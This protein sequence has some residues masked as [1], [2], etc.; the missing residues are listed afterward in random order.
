MIKTDIAWKVPWKFAYNLFAG[1][2]PENRCHVIL[3]VYCVK[4]KVYS[5]FS[6]SQHQCAIPGLEGRSFDYLG[7]LNCAFKACERQNIPA[8]QV[9][10]HIRLKSFEVS[11]SSCCRFSWLISLLPTEVQNKWLGVSCGLWMTSL[12]PVL[13]IDYR[14]HVTSAV[15][16]SSAKCVW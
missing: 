9:R 11:F 14:A 15:P 5:C 1:V 12:L 3:V 7:L 16:F 4:K 6:E 8:R 13:S 10:K 2:M